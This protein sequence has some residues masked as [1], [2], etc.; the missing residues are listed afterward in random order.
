ME[1]KQIVINR[2]VPINPIKFQIDKN[3]LC[4]ANQL[5]GIGCAEFHDCKCNAI[6][7]LGVLSIWY[8]ECLITKI[9][10]SH[11]CLFVWWE[12]L[13]WKNCLHIETGPWFLVSQWYMGYYCLSRMPCAWLLKVHFQHPRLLVLCAQM[14]DGGEYSLSYHYDITW[15]SWRLRSPDIWVFVLF[16]L[17]VKS[18]I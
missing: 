11:N 5:S 16:Q 1:K 17:T 2:K 6:L 18:L 3:V 13:Y 14:L 4:L 8:I 15:V 7:Y 10:R 12:C 9:R